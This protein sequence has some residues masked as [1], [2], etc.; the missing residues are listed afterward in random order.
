MRVFR[1]LVLC[2]FSSGAFASQ[3]DWFQVGA[4]IY[5]DIYLLGVDKAKEKHGELDFNLLSKEDSF[6]VG[7]GF[8]NRQ[9]TLLSQLH[10]KGQEY[11]ITPEIRCSKIVGFKASE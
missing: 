11:T 7:T 5:N 9:A 8:G 1:L 2:M 6:E 4:C 10:S 3:A